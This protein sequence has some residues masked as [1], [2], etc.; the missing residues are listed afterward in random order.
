[1]CQFCA[2]DDI[3]F[4]SADENENGNTLLKNGRLVNLVCRIHIFN[5]I[6]RKQ[7]RKLYAAGL[8]LRDGVK[9]IAIK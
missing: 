2:G 9:S 3:R 4:C 7:D 1:M 5:V 6:A 8:K